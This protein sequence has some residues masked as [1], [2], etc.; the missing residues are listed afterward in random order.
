VLIR[1]ATGRWPA[2][3]CA[4]AQPRSGPHIHLMEEAATGGVGHPGAVEQDTELIGELLGL[5]HRGVGM[6][7][8]RMDITGARWDLPTAQAILTLPCPGSG[9]SMPRCG[10]QGGSSLR[11]ASIAF[12]RA[13]HG[14]FLE[15]STRSDAEIRTRPNRTVRP[16]EGDAACVL[17]VTR[18]DKKYGM[19]R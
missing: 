12:A 16:H 2:P 3:G 4:S 18:Q 6:V 7:T 5:L 13:L 10:G 1:K 8:D 9:R 14:L 11:K 19:T 15:A 17:T